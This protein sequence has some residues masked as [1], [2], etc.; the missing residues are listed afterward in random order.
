[1][2]AC[3]RDGF[4]AVPGTRDACCAQVRAA[5]LNHGGRE[6]QAGPG[7]PAQASGVSLQPSPVPRVMTSSPGAISPA[8]QGG[9]SASLA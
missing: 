1:M 2:R 3:R 9:R 4:N 7:L 5:P 6:N 8:A